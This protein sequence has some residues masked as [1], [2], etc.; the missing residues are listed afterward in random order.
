AHFAIFSVNTPLSMSVLLPMEFAA[1]LFFVTAPSAIFDSTT[2]PSA[3]A[4]IPIAP[5]ITS[6]ATMRGL[7]TAFD[8]LFNSCKFLSSQI[9]EKIN[10][11]YAIVSSPQK[12]PHRR[13]CY[14]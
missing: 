1:I 4:D 14:L 9:D 5:G 6:P 3:N 2:A 8:I 13:L 11:E 12:E 7:A 10:A